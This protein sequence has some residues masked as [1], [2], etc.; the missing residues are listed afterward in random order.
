MDNETF[1]VQSR[2]D[3]CVGNNEGCDGLF[4]TA[5]LIGYR[6]NR[7]RENNFFRDDFTST[8]ESIR[9]DGLPVDVLRC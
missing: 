7:E 8:A 5:F 3:L 1:K 6:H 4:L 9:N 2:V